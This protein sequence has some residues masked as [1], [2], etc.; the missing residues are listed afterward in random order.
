MEL[1]KEAHS[2]INYFIYMPQTLAELIN[3]NY[4]GDVE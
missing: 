3:K 1:V 4:T 2:I